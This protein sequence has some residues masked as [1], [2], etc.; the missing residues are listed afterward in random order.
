MITNCVLLDILVFF[1]I[2]ASTEC[3]L[4]Y[5]CADSIKG[6]E[7]MSDIKGME[8]DFV[9]HKNKTT[10]DKA[11][12]PTY[13][14]NCTQVV[15]ATTCIIERIDSRGA[16]EAFIRDCSDGYTFSIPLDRLTN[17]EP[18]NMTTCGFTGIGYVVCVTLCKEDLC[19]GPQ[20]NNGHVHLA[21]I[22]HLFILLSVFYIVHVWREITANTKY[23]VCWCEKMYRCFSSKP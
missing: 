2:F 11:Y 1:S 10:H 6:G 3:L 9:Y 20:V 22:N 23:D 7:C 19:N 21:L 5:Q 18:D 12:K 13:I 8:Q 16:T 4:C 15:N 14:K 17:L